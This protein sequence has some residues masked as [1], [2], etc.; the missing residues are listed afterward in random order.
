MA[1]P[2][3]KRVAD[4]QFDSKIFWKRAGQ[5]NIIETGPEAK[6]WGKCHSEEGFEGFL[7]I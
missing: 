6:D 4:S 1:K 3:K 2:V 7:K 5:R